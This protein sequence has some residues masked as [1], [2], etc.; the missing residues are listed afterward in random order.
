MKGNKIALF[1]A[2]AVI[3]LG[4]V[5][6]AAS[7]SGDAGSTL[8]MLGILTVFGALG[9]M[10]MAK[11]GQSVALG[12]V[13]GFIL[14]WIGLI[15]CALISK[16]A[17]YLDKDEMLCPHCKETIKAGA[18]TCKHCKKDPRVQPS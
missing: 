5:I 10:I 3:I 12:W 8:V 18:T 4:F 9:G 7:R 6:S 16:K 17:G 13:L 15:I 11:K 2:I 14:N 1:V